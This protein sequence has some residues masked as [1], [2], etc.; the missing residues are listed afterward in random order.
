[1]K[2]DEVMKY[3]EE[4][5]LNELSIELNSP[6]TEA[7]VRESGIDSI[8]LMALTVYLENKY[9][10]VGDEIFVNYDND[11]KFIDIIDIV[12]EQIKE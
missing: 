4:V 7:L 9:G 12:L 5:L 3:I 2:K 8:S 1:M 6:S 11:I 10:I